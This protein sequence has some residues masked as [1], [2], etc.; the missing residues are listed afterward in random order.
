MQVLLFVNEAYNHHAR[1]IDLEVSLSPGEYTI[2]VIA[3]W[4][5]KEY[6]FFLSFYGCVKLDLK[7]LYTREMPKML[8]QSLD[9]ESIEKGTMSSKGPVNEY[10][11]YHEDSNLIIVT[12]ENTGDDSNYT[13][14]LTKV[15]FD[16]LTLINGRS[17]EENFKGK[18]KEELTSMKKDSSKNKRWSTFLKAGG[19][20]TWVISTNEPYHPDNLRKYKF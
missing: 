12:A 6:D 5:A 3:D 15:A 13:L 9:K 10:T 19:K 17:Q 11:L 4:K 14:D 1:N 20:Y 7:K 8:T 18:T 16:N 2:H